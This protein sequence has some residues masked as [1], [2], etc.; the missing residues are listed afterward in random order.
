VFTKLPQSP[1]CLSCLIC[2]HKAPPVIQFLFE[3]LLKQDWERGD[4][5]IFVDNGISEERH[6]YV[7]DSLDLLEKIGVHIVHV[8]E[9]QP[10]LT[11]ARLKSFEFSKNPWLVLLDDD[12]SLKPNAL[13]F[14]RRIISENNELGGICPRI[15]PIW[16]KS[17]PAWMIVLGH[18]VLS[19]NYSTLI[20]NPMLFAIWKGGMT[21]IRPPGGGM[22]IH[23]SVAESFV[24]LCKETPIIRKLGRVGSRLLA[25]EDFILYNQIY[26]LRMP[27]AYADNII[28][29]HHIPES[30]MNFRYLVRIT[31]WAHFSFGFLGIMR[32]GKYRVLFSIYRHTGVLI[33]SMLWNAR[34]MLLWQ[35]VVGYATMLAG[36]WIGAFKGLL[37]KDA[38][39]ISIDPS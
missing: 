34:Y 11:N 24:K 4:E 16:A 29:E 36:A 17:T 23:R 7:K 18:H 19:Y 8:K 22:I 5:I 9:T 27:T 25:C 6:Q 21:G 39:R 31:F 1:V 35:V 32:W 3:S 2:S 26:M 10:G 13:Q 33:L 20:Q 30:R 38:V 14:L 12:N 15:E 28:V 37:D